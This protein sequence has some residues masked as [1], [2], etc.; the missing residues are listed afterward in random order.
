MPRP[1]GGMQPEQRVQINA[2]LTAVSYV[3]AVVWMACD[4][5]SVARNMFASHLGGFCVRAFYDA[6]GRV[7]RFC[8]C[9]HKNYLINK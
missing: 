6:C 5:A 2:S 3:E 4:V 7:I 1:R 9:I 8:A